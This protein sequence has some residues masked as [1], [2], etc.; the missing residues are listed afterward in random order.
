MQLVFRFVRHAILSC[1]VA[2]SLASVRVAGAPQQAQ[3]AQP[4]EPQAAVQAF[5]SFH[6]SHNMNFTT[7]SVRLRRPWLHPELYKLLLYE[8]KRAADYGRTHRDEPPYFEGDPFTDS[9]EYPESFKIKAVTVNDNNAD[10]SVVF[11]WFQ[12]KKSRKVVDEKSVTVKLE[13]VGTRWLIRD[14]VNGEGKSLRA[15]LS[16]K[17]Y[18]GH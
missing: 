9:Q 3:K 5:Y 10:A 16:R 2:V 12:D 7:A 13:H 14:I 4:S 17:D 18:A 11:Q 1:L 8:M 6:M 15:E